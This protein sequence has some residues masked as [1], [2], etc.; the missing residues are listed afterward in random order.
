MIFRLFTLKMATPE[1]PDPPQSKQYSLRLD[2][3]DRIR[4]LALRDAGFTYIQ[5][6]QQLQISH[7]QVQY[8]CQNQQATPKK[9]RGAPPKLSEAEVDSIIEWI[10]SSKRTRRMPYYK[11]IQELD[12]SVG[13]HALA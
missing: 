2:R 4:V 3:D 12:L 10:T 8:T 6:A 13:K 5:I 7:R 11:V 1:P 9:A